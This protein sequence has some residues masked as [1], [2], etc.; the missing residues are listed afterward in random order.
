MEL[1]EAFQPI[2]SKTRLKKFKKELSRVGSSNVESLEQSLAPPKKVLESQKHTQ[3]LLDQAHKEFQYK[4]INRTKT[5]ID[6]FDVIDLQTKASKALQLMKIEYYQLLDTIT[7]YQRLLPKLN[8]AILNLQRLM[9]NPTAKARIIDPRGKL[10]SKIKQAKNCTS[11]LSVQLTP[12]FEPPI[13]VS[14]KEDDVRRIRRNL[15]VPNLWLPSTQ[16]EMKFSPLLRL[17]SSTSFGTDYTRYYHP[18]AANL[19]DMDFGKARKKKLKKTSD[20]LRIS[21][22]WR[23]GRF[24]LRPKET[25][26]ETRLSLKEQLQIVKKLCKQFASAVSSKRVMII[27]WAAV[28]RQVGCEK[29]IQVIVDEIKPD[30]EKLS[31]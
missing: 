10:Q 27:E 9:N 3:M 6:E 21:G 7:V 5:L 18:K 2:S 31:R 16:M 29:I 20:E 26:S 15:D 22:W 13:V 25:E 17:T 30:L 24:D 4:A 14:A 23:E 8:W 12:Y 19:M 28:A 1:L 11:T